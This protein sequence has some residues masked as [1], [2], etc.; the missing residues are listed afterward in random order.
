MRARTAWSWIAAGGAL[1]ACAGCG[2]KGPLYL[3]EHNATVITHP[4]QPAQ[5]APP[6]GQ[7]QTPAAKGKGKTPQP[8]GPASTTPPQGTP[9]PLPPQSS[10][11]PPLPR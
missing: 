11:P 3:P 1:L 9:P 5:G 7:A 8:P 6:A 10:S 2:F 4:G